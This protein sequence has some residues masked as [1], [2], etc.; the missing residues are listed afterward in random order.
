MLTEVELYNFKSHRHTQ[1][2]FDDSRLH[3]IVGKNSSGKTSILQA[4]HY[5]SLLANGKFEDIFGD[6]TDR[7]PEFLVTIEQNEMTVTVRGFSEADR[8]NWKAGYEFRK[9]YVSIRNHIDNQLWLPVVSWQVDQEE[10]EWQGWE[11]SL[12]EAP[13][14][15]L[16]ALKHGIY[17][18]L[19]ASNLSKA[20]YSEAIAPQV[21]SDGSGLAPA[22]DYLRNEAPDHFQN[23]QNML[24]QIVPG[25]QKIGIRRAKVEI[26]RQRSITVDGKPILYDEDQ[27]VSGQEVVL[28]M[29]TGERIP[30][31][32]ISEGTM[33][34]LGLLTVLV[35]PEHP[36]L[37]LLDDV[38]QGLHPRVQRELM[39]VLKEIIKRNSNLQIIFSTHSPYIVDELEPSQVHV[40]S[41]SV[42]GFTYAK[43][44]DEHPDVEW[45][46]EVLTTGE[47]WDA[48]GEDWV[49]AGDRN[50]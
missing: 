7:A 9:V 24:R 43:R 34:A 36:N 28:D 6:Q 38:E 31:H 13:T 39:T 10:Q 32:T 20:A 22:L 47:F 4:L 2:K 42:S 37:V 1:L 49:I 14:P 3:A 50:G 33:L 15:I 19:I 27:V 30:A 25:V 29:S 44:L 23:L 11:E 45:A 5:L 41:N 40:L 26:N 17:L 16:Q 18:K 21:E 8:Q 48:E 35:N 12:S 46:K